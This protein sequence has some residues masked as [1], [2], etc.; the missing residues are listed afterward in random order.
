MFIKTINFFELDQ[1][2]VYCITCLKTNKKYIGAT[3]SFL[4][5]AARHWFLLTRNQHEC[6]DLQNDF[7]KYNKFFEF[8]V[9]IVEKN[10]KQ[11]LKLEKYIIKSY[12]KTTLY[13]IVDLLEL[14]SGV[15]KK[16][17]LLGQQI[18]MDNQLYVSI[19][20]AERLTKVSKTTIC[21]RLNNQM[22]LSCIRL[23][24]KMV[25]RGKY[26]FIRDGVTYV[27]THEVVFSGLA[28]S[29]NQVRERCD[30]KSLKWK[31]WKKIQ[32]KRSNDY[33]N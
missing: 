32:K 29:N 25:L 20:E 26:N 7:N 21:R 16:K 14:G 3:K 8:K 15:G 19:R 1:T 5:R 17:P 30:S 18:L 10:F 13:N 11:C 22:D 24:K 33:P 28:K 31:N 6:F 2:G 4:Q 12:A 23:N 27:S 9:L